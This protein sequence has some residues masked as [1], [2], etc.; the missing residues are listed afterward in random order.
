MFII[1]YENYAVLGVVG[2]SSSVSAV[3]LNEYVRRAFFMGSIMRGF[4]VFFNIVFP[5]SI[6]IATSS[7]LVVKPVM[8]ESPVCPVCIGLRQ[9]S[10]N[11]GAGVV[12]PLIYNQLIYLASI[13]YSHLYHLPSINVSISKGLV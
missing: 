2:L 5:A 3:V 9:A 8:G 12:Y 7:V 13:H 10:I 6:S 11:I 1:R 4:S